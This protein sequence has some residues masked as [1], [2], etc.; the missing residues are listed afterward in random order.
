M[1][2]QGGFLDQRRH[3][4]A[5][6][7]AALAINGAVL[8]ALIFSAPAIEEKLPT[9]LD[10]IAIPIIEPDPVPPPPPEPRERAVTQPLPQPPTPSRSILPPT[11]TDFVTRIAPPQPPTPF[12]GTTIADPAPAVTPERRSVFVG[13][14]LDRRFADALQPPYPAGKIRS[15]EEGVVTVRVLVGPD[16]R[17]KQVE[18]VDAAD[19]AFYQATAQQALKRW[20]FKPATR[21][22]VAVEG[23]RTMTV[24]FELDS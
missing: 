24:R 18:K 4:P 20:R 1:S 13:P 3:S 6:L 7:T 19:D 8:G 15:E 11:P 9:I 10:T 21:D 14:Q 2:V 5:S 22:G 16:G 23:W 12:V 17:V